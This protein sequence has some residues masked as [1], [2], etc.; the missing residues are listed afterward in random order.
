MSGKQTLKAELTEELMEAKAIQGNFSR[1]VGEIIESLN[2]TASLDYANDKIRNEVMCSL[3]SGIEA[4]NAKDYEGMQ[5]FMHA[6]MQRLNKQGIIDE[7]DNQPRTEAK[8]KLLKLQLT[9]I[10]NEERIT[11]LLAKFGGRDASSAA[12]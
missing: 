2:K 3:L 7:Q 5:K 1:E 12:K 11:K 9:T 4:Y 8:I 6:A 10:H